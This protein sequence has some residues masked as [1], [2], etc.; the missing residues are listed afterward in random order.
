M[1][2][3]TKNIIILH[4]NT[5]IHI[6]AWNLYF[7]CLFILFLSQI[8]QPICAN[9]LFNSLNFVILLYFLYHSLFSWISVIYQN[10]HITYYSLNH[11]YMLY[12]LS[13]I[14]QFHLNNSNFYFI[15]HLL[16]FIIILSYFIINL[17]LITLF[18]III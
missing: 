13:F 17:Y 11:S 10:S 2:L 4:Q 14:L 15:T 9:L 3:L 8:I 7:L 12:I 6:N 1:L 5:F 18:Y 16:I